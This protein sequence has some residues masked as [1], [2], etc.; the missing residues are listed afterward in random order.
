[1][2]TIKVNDKLNYSKDSLVFSAESKRQNKPYARTKIIAGTDAYV[3]E[4]G[5]T[6]FGS[7]I[8]EEENMIVLGGALFTLEKVFNVKSPITVSYLNDI[9]GIA[10]GG[11]TITEH[12]PKDM[13]VCLFGVGIGG[14]GESFTDVKDV[15]YYEREI[16]DMVPLRQTANELLDTEKNKYWFKKKVEV[17]GIEKTAYYLKTFE[18]EPEIKILYKDAEGDEDGSEVP[19]DVYNSPESNTTPTET[20]IEIVFKITKKDVRE[21][22]EDNG[23]IEQTRVNSIGLFTGVKAVIDDVSGEEDYKNVRLFSKL[24]INNEML[25]VSK[26]ITV[27]YRIYAS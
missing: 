14:A 6:R 23:N 8:F 9:M 21:Y 17:D 26:D 4:R 16:I 19:E 24:N 7:K 20:F 5:F 13:G 15:R 18:T 11:P 3:D 27:V 25:T 10:T 12:Y 1:M 2:S 22:F